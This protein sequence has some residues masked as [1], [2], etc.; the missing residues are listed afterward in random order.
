MK[1]VWYEAR[2]VILEAFYKNDNLCL[3]ISD[4]PGRCQAQLLLQVV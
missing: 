4:T 1:S 3:W 2:N